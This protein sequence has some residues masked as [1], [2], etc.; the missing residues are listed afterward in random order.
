MQKLITI[1]DYMHELDESRL[2]KVLGIEKRVWEDFLEDFCDIMTNSSTII[3]FSHQVKKFPRALLA[4]LIAQLFAGEA[5]LA[6]HYAYREIWGL[7]ASCWID[8]VERDL[9]EEGDGPVDP[10]V[11]FQ[12]PQIF[13]QTI[14]GSAFVVYLYCYHS[15]Y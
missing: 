7:L 1:N 15:I 13:S 2:C 12:R 14:F 8:E 11:F 10:L 6:L 5:F 9:N 4:M 3:E